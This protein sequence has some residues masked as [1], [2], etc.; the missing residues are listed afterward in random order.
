[1][2]GFTPPSAVEEVMETI[3]TLVLDNGTH[4]TVG[5]VGGRY[6]YSALTLGGHRDVALKV[7][8]QETLPSY[9]YQVTQG[10][11]T[12]WE[13]WSGV[14]DSTNGEAAPSHNHHFLGAIGQWFYEALAGVQLQPLEVG[15]GNSTQLPSAGARAW[16]RFTVRP[17]ITDQQALSGMA[18][19]L[20]TRRGLLRVA[21]ANLTSLARDCG[22]GRLLSEHADDADIITCALLPRADGASF[23]LN[24]TIPVNA[25]AELAIPCVGKDGGRIGING[26]TAWS[27]GAYVPGVAEG[28]IS[29]TLSTTSAHGCRVTFAVVSGSYAF[30]AMLDEGL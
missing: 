26:H 14:P 27:A 17:E 18:V 30:S 28:V 19:S 8:L 10:A 6:L 13:N 9:G 21:W 1:M 23:I 25:A 2:R 16:G 3:K 22:E 12:L 15:V 20:N 4:A 11:T 29:G 5:F 7:A 24:A